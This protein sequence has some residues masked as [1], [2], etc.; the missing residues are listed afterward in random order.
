MKTV[1]NLYNSPVHFYVMSETNSSR[2]VQPTMPWE[3]TL[4]EHHTSLVLARAMNPGMPS[5]NMLLVLGADGNPYCKFD[6][7]ALQWFTSSLFI[8]G[9][10]AALPAGHVTK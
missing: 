4:A 6:S 2:Y 8:A 5:P 3:A 9:V 1:S 10:F 7:Q